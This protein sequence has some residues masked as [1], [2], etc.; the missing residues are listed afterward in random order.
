[1]P[2][3][4]LQGKSDEMMPAASARAYALRPPGAVY[5]ELA[6]G[7]FIL[8]SRYEQVRPLI[9]S[10]LLGLEQ[11]APGSPAFVGKPKR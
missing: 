9:A 10:F 8:L 4:V 6:G 1:L 11:R 7:H 2:T 5:R 3:L